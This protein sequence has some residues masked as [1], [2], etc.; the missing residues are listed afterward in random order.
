[1]RPSHHA[2]PRGCPSLLPGFALTLACFAARRLG[3]R[4]WKYFRRSGAGLWWAGLVEPRA[5]SRRRA[6]RG[7]S[8]ESAAA[9]GC[10]PPCPPLDTQRL[11]FVHR[12]HLRLRAIGTEGVPRWLAPFTGSWLRRTRSVG[13]SA[14]L[15]QWS[16]REYSIVFLGIPE[17][18]A[19]PGSCTTTPPPR[20]FT[21]RTPATPS[22]RLPLR[23]TA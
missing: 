9:R 20:S 23:T 7:S 16:T 21:S 8:R 22:S 13:M 6:S 5:S 15:R 10:A 3:P 11:L 1:Y 2:P 4:A 14:R 17:K 18:A 12:C 19:S